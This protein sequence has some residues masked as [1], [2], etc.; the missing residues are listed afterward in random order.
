MGNAFAMA[1]QGNGG[2]RPGARHG[3]YGEAADGI[4]RRFP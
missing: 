3:L 2:D 1:K 4:V